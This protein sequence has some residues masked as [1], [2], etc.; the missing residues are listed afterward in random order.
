MFIQ[1]F[2][3]LSLFTGL[4][5]DQSSYVFLTGRNDG[6]GTRTTFLA[7][8]GYPIART[9]NQYK[10]DSNGTTLTKLQVWPTGDGS[11]AST[12]WNTDTE[13]N[14]GYSSGSGLTNVMK[15]ASGNVTVYEADGATVS[16]EPAPVSILGYQ[17]TKDANDS[18]AGGNGGR[19]LSYNGF[20]VTYTGSD[21]SAATRKAIING[22]YTM[23]GY[24]HLY[25]RTAVNFTTPANDLDRLYKTIRDG[26][27]AA[28]LSNSGIPLSEMTVVSRTTDG[29]VVAP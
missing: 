12:I 26:C 16:F 29:G 21:I 1:G 6:S 28:N 9:L 3:P 15:A 5:A 11:N 17:S 7:E 22:Q 8:T 10:S 18:V 13:G 24:E 19:V 25:S 14:G 4:D 2:Q 20:N 23:W 27:T